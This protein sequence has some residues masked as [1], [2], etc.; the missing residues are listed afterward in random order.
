[1]ANQ[2]VKK[3]KVPE[4]LKQSRSSARSRL[5][6]LELPTLKSRGWEFTDLAT[7]DPQKYKVSKNGS[8]GAFNNAV[9]LFSPEDGG[10][11]LDQIDAT[12]LPSS[13]GDQ[14]AQDATDGEKPK[15]P[16]VMS[17][18]QAVSDFPWL[19]EKYLSTVVTADDYFVAENC[20]KWSGGAFVY[21]PAGHKL[22]LPVQ[23]TTVQQSPGSALFW[24]TLVVLEEASEAEIWEQYISSDDAVDGLFNTVVELHVGNGASLRYICGQGLSRSSWIFGSQRAHLDRDASIDWITLGFGSASGKIRMETKLAGDGS[25]AKV[26]GFY[27]GYESQHLDFDTTQEHAAEHTSSDLAFRGLLEDQA[28][29]V[30]RG[31][32]EVD[33]GAQRTDAFQESRNL[34]LSKQAHADAIPGLEIEADDVRCTH[35]AAIAQIDETQVFYLM[36][37]GLTRKAATRIVIDGFMQALV[38]RL[39]KGRLHDAVSEALER[40]LEKILGDQTPAH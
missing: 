18:E 32:I 21:V 22:D 39:D 6:K 9:P 14:R 23:I 4:W 31:M 40:R 27:A 15:H 38:E 28:T 5:S 33:P 35:A 25:S 36:S 19:V 11:R 20:A 16:V 30:W 7:F 3:G 37:R 13:G 34:L 8:A 29:A 2:T 24:R 26:T 1:M 17:L 10:I 12:S